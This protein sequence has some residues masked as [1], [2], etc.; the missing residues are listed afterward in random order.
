MYQQQGVISKNKKNSI[1]QNFPNRSFRV[2]HQN[3]HIFIL[4]VAAHSV[5]MAIFFFQSHI[6][7]RSSVE[8]DAVDNKINGFQHSEII[9][10]TFVVFMWIQKK[11]Y[12]ELVANNF[13]LLSF[14][15]C[16]IS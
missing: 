4:H 1:S 5:F 9:T 2:I 10:M 15:F 3:D 16:G 12:I 13:Y 14:F 7:F 11:I 8:S 6:L